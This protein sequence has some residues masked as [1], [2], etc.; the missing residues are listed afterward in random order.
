[1]AKPVAKKH[2]RERNPC[3]ILSYIYASE[4]SY[5]ENFMRILMDYKLFL[6][7]F[8]FIFIVLKSCMIFFLFKKKTNTCHDY[9]KNKTVAVEIIFWRSVASSY[10][11]SHHFLNR[12]SKIVNSF[13]C[14]LF[15]S[16]L[17]FHSNR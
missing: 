13:V 11:V 9:S 17:T 14:L 15:R 7:F 16:F 2:T 10:H 4:I 5:S 3:A 6:L 12:Y 8:F 1:M